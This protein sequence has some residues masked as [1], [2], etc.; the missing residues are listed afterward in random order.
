MEDTARDLHDRRTAPATV[1]PM[2]VEPEIHMANFVR[3]DQPRA[4]WDRSIDDLE[5]ILVLEGLFEYEQGGRR[6]LQ[7]PG[8]VLLIL[9]GQRHAYRRARGCL[10]ARFSCIHCELLPGA[11]WLRGDY[12]VD[13]P[14]QILTT[15]DDLAQIAERFRAAA[16]CF[17]GCSPLRAPLLRNRLREIWLLLSE[18]WLRSCERPMSRRTRSMVEYL[19]QH[20]PL[21]PD[22]QD[23]ASRFGLSPQHVNHLFKEEVG[24]SP[25]AFVHRECCQLAHRLILEESLSVQEVAQRVGFDDPCYFSR[26]FTRIIG[27]PPSR[28]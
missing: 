12:R 6:W 26:V 5:L 19:R 17:A 18:R 4:V 27:F 2:E 21:H 24:L 8:Q 16:E 1:L 28:V 9:P 22:R 14:P 13:P 20:A 7:K 3:V 25:T 10:S 15:M 23:L 11:S